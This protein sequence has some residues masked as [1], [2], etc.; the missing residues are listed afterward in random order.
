MSYID[1]IAGTVRQAGIDREIGAGV[2]LRRGWDYWEPHR[3]AGDTS[4]RFDPRDTVRWATSKPDTDGGGMA[5]LPHQHMLGSAALPPK[6]LPVLDA[7]MDARHLVAGISRQCLVRPSDAGDRVGANPYLVADTRKLCPSSRHLMALVGHPPRDLAIWL[8]DLRRHDPDLFRLVL[9]KKFRAALMRDSGII[10]RPWP[11]A[12]RRLWQDGEAD[13]LPPFLVA[14]LCA[15]LARAAMNHAGLVALA[16]D[17][18]VELTTKRLIDRVGTS[19]GPGMTAAATRAIEHAPYQTLALG[20]PDA[21]IAAKDA[22]AMQAWVRTAAS[23]LALAAGER[24][25]IDIAPRTPDEA[26]FLRAGFA[27]HPQNLPEPRKDKGHSI[28]PRR[29]GLFWG[30][31]WR[32]NAAVRLLEI[33]ATAREWN[34]HYRQGSPPLPGMTSYRMANPVAQALVAIRFR[35]TAEVSPGAAK[36]LLG[37]MLSPEKKAL[38]F[39]RWTADHIEP[40]M[41]D[42]HIGLKAGLDLQEQALAAMDRLPEP[43]AFG[44]TARSQAHLWIDDAGDDIAHYRRFQADAVRGH[45]EALLGTLPPALQDTA[46]VPAE[47]VALLGRQHGITPRQGGIGHNQPLPLSMTLDP[48]AAEGAQLEGQRVSGLST[49]PMLARM[50]RRSAKP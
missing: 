28:Q 27:A 47:V 42:E 8:D 1:A 25:G 12:V 50:L 6:T 31:A 19:V 22:E 32:L 7:S 43:G 5:R 46:R 14:V 15:E 35:W 9:A 16:F 33:A 11:D 41:V 18:E 21:I 44:Y 10:L 38:G 26:R 37:E 23:S 24:G 3:P 13:Y 39:R 29:T 4:S 17:G 34:R 2:A 49:D 45:E 40:L 48:L 36:T 20:L 30:L